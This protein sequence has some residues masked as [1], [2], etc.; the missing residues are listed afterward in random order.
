MQF[1]FTLSNEIEGDY[2]ISNPD[3][4]REIK[5]KLERHPDFHSLVEKIEV[6]LMFYGSN[7]VEDGGYDYIKTI[8]E[9][10]GI[11]AIIEILIEISEDEGDTWD[12]F[13]TG[14]LELSDLQEFS[15][16]ERYF[17]LQ[18]PIIQTD[19]WSKFINRFDT[20]VDIRGVV[21][22]D[23]NNAV[24]Q[25]DSI[26]LQMAGQTIEKVSNFTGEASESAEVLA[27]Q[28]LQRFSQVGL[29]PER[30]EIL[31]TFT[32]P[33]ALQTTNDVA[34]VIE[35]KEEGI[36][37][38]DVY[39]NMTAQVL[40]GT[41]VNNIN[42]VLYYKI[43]DEAPVSIVF[44][45]ENFAPT[46][47]TPTS[48]FDMTGSVNLGNRIPTDLIYIYGFWSVAQDS[49]AELE[50]TF[51]L[52]GDISVTIQSIYPD[53]TA[54]AFL[55]HDVGE[56]I[57]RR[58][59]GI[60]NSFYS[61]NLGGLVHG[62]SEE[63]C[64]S[65]YAITKGLHVRGYTL[66]E[67]P[68]FQSFK[69]FWEG[70]N[71][72][73]SLGL[74]YELLYTSPDSEVIRVEPIRYFYDESNYSFSF[75]YVDGIKRSYDKGHIFKSVNI[76]YQKWSAESAGGIDDP[77]TKK[78]Y[79]TVFKQIGTDVSTLSRFIAAGLAIEQTRRNR[80]EQGKDWRLDEDTMIIALNLDGSPDYQPEFDE[81]FTG[82]TGLKN[83][84]TRYNLRLTPAWNFLRWI[85]YFRGCLQKYTDSEFTFQSSEGN[86]DFG[87]TMES[88]SDCILVT[89]EEVSENM[90]IPVD[91]SY[92]ANDFIHLPD[93][94]EFEYKMAW[95]DYKTI[96]DNKRLAI[97]VS[98][99]DANHQLCHI[100]VLEYAP[101]E[102]KAT[103]EA[104]VGGR[105]EAALP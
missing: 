72:I 71:P 96:R 100:D 37:T 58:T 11:N 78:T 6:P 20:P 97:R 46:Q 59:T 13:F 66:S 76:G 61:E 53:T 87:A 90:N 30:K 25:A 79:A 51:Y 82:I 4:W 36:M 18:A 35:I 81:N 9:E 88:D 34:N 57:V 70:I 54:D 23:G 103:V 95:Q 42:V 15:E 41:D 1:R 89:D 85:A 60:H 67:K 16:G 52:S 27:A 19:L 77:Q 40:V 31:D 73:F 102:A 26:T 68:F 92:G 33:F 63:G 94:L 43:N 10:Q 74:G 48:S 105:T 83:S 39:I 99:T 65:R 93:K 28:T 22:L 21:D 5:I 38:I 47:N 49:T 29:T 98:K 80:A 104:W 17:K 12:E 32:L 69:Q 56:A 75:D 64:N 3:G 44:D 45:S 101:E 7:G 55:L 8:E 91:I 24:P 62:Y 86:S 14:N 84:D 2:P 50:A